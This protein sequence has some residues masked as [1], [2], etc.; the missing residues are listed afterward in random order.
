MGYWSDETA[1][2][3]ITTSLSNEGTL[4][5]KGSQDIDVTCSVNVSACGETITLSLEDGYGPDS[6]RTMLRLPIGT[7]TMTFVYGGETSLTLDVNVAERI[8]DVERD[9]WD[10]YRDRRTSDDSGEL[11]CSGWWPEVEK[12]LNDVPVKVW[13][14]G[15]VRYLAILEEVIEYLAPILDLEFEWVDT[16][17]E[18]D[19]RAY[20]GI[21]RSEADGWRELVVNADYLGWAGW[22]GS[23]SVNGETLSGYVFV[24]MLSDPQWTANNQNTAKSIILHEVV[25]AMASVGHTNRPAS[26][27]H[28]SGLKW[29]SPMDEALLRLNAHH[30]VRPGMTIQEVESLL[31]FRDDLLD[32]PQSVEPNTM[33]MI[34]RTSVDLLNSGTAR[35]KMRG[36]WTDQRCNFLFGSRRGLA[37][38]ETVYDNFEDEPP[39]VHI[40]DHTSHIY[41]AWSEEAGEWRHWTKDDGAWKMV[42]R[43]AITDAT[44]WW[45]WNG[46]L[47]KTL[48]SLINDGST[49]DI[50]IIDRSNGTITLEATLDKSYPTLWNWE[51]NDEVEL[52]LTLD[53]TAYTL[54]GY[55]WRRIRKQPTGGCDTYEEEASMAEIG[56]KVEIPESIRKE[57]E[58]Q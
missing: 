38:Y 45:V 19:F 36:G 3:E 47:T 25:H 51:E 43:N 1:N 11:S 40:D 42:E 57:L 27:L 34:W 16:E 50:K 44:N 48:R 29:L 58:S 23:N 26:I 18:A 4:P 54:Q 5:F 8:L 24:W 28:G 12:W 20:V 52:E 6:A 37:T 9:V 55:K 39:L 7:T 56:I 46:K 21:P 2:V 41:I 14:T 15:D 31:V 10:C 35:F 17:E 53:D 49:D 22:A 30:L 32:K 13:G 33:Q